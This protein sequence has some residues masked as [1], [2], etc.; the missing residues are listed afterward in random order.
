MKIIRTIL[1]ITAISLFSSSC[2]SSGDDILPQDNEKVF[3]TFGISQ[4]DQLTR[5]NFASLGSDYAA[6]RWEID[7]VIGMCASVS[8][9]FDQIT[10]TSVVEDDRLASASGSVTFDTKFLAVYPR[11]AA[12]QKINENTV[13]VILPITQRISSDNHCID[14]NALLQIGYTTGGTIAMNTP[15]SFLVFNT[16]DN[17]NISWVKVTAYN[18]D[19]TP[20]G[21]VGDIEASKSESSS[22]EL[23]KEHTATNEVTCTPSGTY[24]DSNRKYAIAIRPGK[25]GYLIVEN[26]IGQKYKISKMSTG[27]VLQFNRAEYH[28]FPAFDKKTN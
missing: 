24:F 15:C 21:I 28:M 9:S 10:V 13:R 3:M 1:S 4:T 18:S 16:G 20:F 26:S 14:K 23:G 5:A 2:S 22:F 27:A 8:S 25:P 11:N 7:D 17:D 19:N 12:S 6:F